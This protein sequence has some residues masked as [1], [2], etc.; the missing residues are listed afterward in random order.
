MDISV[1][2]SKR[3]RTINSEASEIDRPSKTIKYTG[4]GV[5]DHISQSNEPHLQTDAAEETI[6]SSHTQLLKSIGGHIRELTHKKG[7]LEGEGTEPL[8]KSAARRLKKRN[9]LEN[10][11]SRGPCV[12]EPLSC[13]ANKETALEYLKMW[14]EEREKWSFK[15]KTQFWLLQN[16][17]YKSKV[18]PSSN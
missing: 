1:K 3:K 18:C 13:V 5:Y 9:K 11:Q 17:Y 8:S 6:V 2:R 4:N 14:S 16:M 15:K 12:E 10:G 7:T